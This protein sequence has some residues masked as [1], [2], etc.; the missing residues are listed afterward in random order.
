MHGLQGVMCRM[1][2]AAWE[3]G[4]GAAN[5]S[6]WVQLRALLTQM[7]QGPWV[8]GQGVEEVLLQGSWWPAHVQCLGPLK[9]QAW[10]G[11]VR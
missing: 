9:V 8:P 7:L 10:L 1:A 11:L 4:D 3:Q 6:Y 2:A 5:G